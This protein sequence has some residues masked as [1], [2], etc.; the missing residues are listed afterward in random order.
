[1]ITAAEGDVIF[2]MIRFTTT[3]ARTF[4]T[5]IT[6]RFDITPVHLVEV[7]IAYLGLHNKCCLKAL[8]Q[9]VSFIFF[10]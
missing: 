5:P 7:F 8:P 3:P 9:R 10:G 6:G 1:M 4:I 2:T